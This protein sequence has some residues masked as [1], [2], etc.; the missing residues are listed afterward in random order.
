MVNPR[1]ARAARSHWPHGRPWL[2]RLPEPSPTNPAAPIAGAGRDPLT[3]EPASG[4]GRDPVT[5]EPISGAGRAIRTPARN[6]LTGAPTSGA[7]RDPVT[8]QPAS[9]VGRDQK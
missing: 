3:G 2:T 6:P 5:G 4:A 1:R 7:G 9:G 8:G